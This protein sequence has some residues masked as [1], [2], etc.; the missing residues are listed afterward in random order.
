[1]K[2]IV[3]REL[4]APSVMQLEEVAPLE[5]AAGQVRVELKAIGVNPIDTYLRGGVQGYQPALPFTPGMDG[6]GVITATGSDVTDRHV[7]QRVYLC[8]SATGTY[9]EETLCAAEQAQPLPDHVSF[10]QGAGVHIPYYT[11]YRALIQRAQTQPGETVLIHGASGAVGIAAMQWCKQ[12]GVTLIAS[13]STE[14]GQRLAQGQGADLV[15]DHRSP[16]HYNVIMEFTEGR[17][18]DV[19]IEMMAH[20]N[21]EDDLHIMALG[22]RV[23][24]V[25]SRGQ[26]AITPRAAMVKDLSIL[27]MT[28][29]NLAGSARDQAHAAIRAGLDKQTLAPIIREELSLTN[30]ADAHERVMTPGAYGKI[31]LIP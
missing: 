17:G 13:A 19:I 22:G 16:D 21:L 20:I 11:A 3:V 23:V 18:V 7:G 24:T 28:L 9:A 14:E 8:G 30:A 6:A 25:G 15:V 10:V 12:L 26:I 31:I 27:G 1:M 29:M 4:G 2:A 5:P